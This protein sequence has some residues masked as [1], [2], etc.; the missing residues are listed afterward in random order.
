[1][2]QNSSGYEYPSQGYHCR[3]RLRLILRFAEFGQLGTLQALVP[4]RPTR[5]L[6][7]VDMSRGV[8]E[9]QSDPMYP[10]RFV[11][12]PPGTAAGSQQLGPQ[13]QSS[14]SDNLTQAIEGIVPHEFHLGRNGLR[15]PSTLSVSFPFI[16]C[17]I[18]PRTLRSAAVEFYLGTV[19]ESQA[20]A[21]IAGV[22][23]SSTQDGAQNTDGEPLD[24]IADTWTDGAGQPRTNLRFQGWVDSWHCKWDDRDVS[25]VK[26]ECIDNTRL[27]L[28][29]HAPAK[30][31]VSKDLPLDQAFAKYLTFSPTF[32]GLS[33]EYRPIGTTAPKL[34]D[35]LHS[36]AFLPGQ[37]P[38][39]SRVAGASETPSVFDYLTDIAG[40]LGHSLYMDGTTL[41]I[42]RVRSL[43]S[44]SAQT[45]YNDPYLPRTMP[46]GSVL[47]VRRMI[48]GRNLSEVGVKRHFASKAPQ[49]ISVRAYNP[50]NKGVLVERFP[51]KQ[52]KQVYA[53]P[54]NGSTEERWL[55]IRMPGGVVDRPTMRIYAQQVYESLWRQ[56]LGVEI[57]TSNLSAFG[58]GND[59]PDL[60]D[61]Q[62]GDPVEVL[63]ARDDYY[64]TLGQMQTQLDAVAANA[65][66]LR[67]AGFP[68]AFA[69]AYAKAY[70]DAGFTQVFRLHQVDISG[71]IDDGVE[72]T[73]RLVNYV[74]VT[75]D[76]S[77][78]TGEEPV[79]VPPAH[80]PA[81]PK[82]GPPPAGPAFPPSENI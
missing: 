6:S 48:Y 74:E 31:Q 46:D 42:Q 23:S 43:T 58:G 76:K 13:A 67:K 65:D 68:D 55:E 26:L 41:V 62:F 8:L 73:L 24:L 30:G 29:M 4:P 75:S 50:D 2:T 52:D 82:I 45:R 17:P 79:A 33:V 37:G 9:V 61:A 16:A 36:S 81:N 22:G 59:D 14:S 44:A 20:M 3:W 64:S 7:G 27:M 10:G 19:S 15:T 1:M 39:L 53:L 80:A 35:V 32:A 21:Q 60:L 18:D 66:L 5:S 63:F 40:A 78:S 72:L 54:G 25:T 47:S 38:P 12:L 56:E 71:S 69:N 51:S 49:N 34:G 28:N 77:L 11:L 70:T 57:K